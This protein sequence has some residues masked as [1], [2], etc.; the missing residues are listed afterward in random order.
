M[1]GISISAGSTNMRMAASIM[2]P[3]EGSRAEEAAESSAEKS[4]ELVK[5]TPSTAASTVA[6]AGKG[7]A[8]NSLA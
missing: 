7:A 3:A 6:T 8:I 2:K 5:S 1:S 4:R